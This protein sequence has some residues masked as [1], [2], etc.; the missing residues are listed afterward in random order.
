MKDLAQWEAENPAEDITGDPIT[1]PRALVYVQLSEPLAADATP[2]V[3]V[4]GGAV[5]DLAGN[6][7]NSKTLSKSTDWIAPTLTVT[8]TGT[9]DDRP[10]ANAKGAF[11]VDVTSDEE[12][13]RRPKVYFVEITG[14]DWTPRDTTTTTDDV[15]NYVITSDDT[16]SSTGNANVDEMQNLT[17]QETETHW[18]KSY[19]V[20]SIEPHFEGLFGVVVVGQDDKENIGA[21]AGWSAHPHREGTGAANDARP[22]EGDELDPAKMHDAGLLAE[23]DKVFNNDNKASNGTTDI[24]GK[25]GTVTPRSDKDGKVTESANPFVKLDFGMEKGEYDDGEF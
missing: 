6:S 16:Q 18:A 15:W 13:R 11:K 25:I 3:V 12:L 24:S 17:L 21:T 22:G 14:M 9:A 2:S 5:I 7:N 1:E 8:V 23:I 20:S 4:L 10:V 19:K